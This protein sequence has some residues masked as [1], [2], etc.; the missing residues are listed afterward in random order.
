MRIV[1]RLAL[2]GVSLATALITLTGCSES[3]DGPSAA[4]ENA[5]RDAVNSLVSFVSVA[6]ARGKHQA[7]LQQCNDWFDEHPSCRQIVLNGL[8]PI[9][10]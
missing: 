6:D 2:V 8:A 5:V 4:C 9:V 10:H 1:A 7:A 3:S